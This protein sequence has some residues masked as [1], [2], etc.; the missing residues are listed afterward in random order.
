MT[1]KARVV[2]TATM[3]LL[4][5]L[6]SVAEA[7]FDDLIRHVPES[8]TAVVLVDA[9]AMFSSQIAKAEGW[10]A[11]RVEH[12]AAGMTSIPP[13]AKSLVIAAELDPHAMRAKWEVAVAKVDTSIKSM[14][15]YAKQVGGSLDQLGPVQAVRL[16]DNSFLLQFPDGVVGAMAPGDRQK[17][18]YWIN[19][20]NRGLSVYLTKALADIDS[21]AHI[22]M[23]MDL[24]HAFSADDL[25]RGMEKFDAV[26]QSQV[27]LADLA[28]F[29]ATVNGITL[30]ISFRDKPY[31][32]VA[33]DFA[34]DAAI[35]SKIAKPLMLEILGAY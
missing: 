16:P 29:M 21:N 35:A 5:L 30:E 31:G 23:A 15:D 12:F 32:M 11:N 18:G 7:Q 10:Q 25:Q 34:E 4:C 26:K 13:L 6:G 14:S 33:L 1:R 17:A 20:P 8:A 9:D 2:A 22:V 28:K 27:N 24:A 19:R 3:A